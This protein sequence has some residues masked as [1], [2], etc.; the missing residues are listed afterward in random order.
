MP[1]CTL[2]QVLNRTWLLVRESIAQK[3]EE[4]DYESSKSRVWWCLTGSFSFLPIHA[5]FPP[6]KPNL[7]MM[8]VVV[9]SYTFTISTL[10]QAQQRNKH[11]RPT[12][13]MLAVG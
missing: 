1:S 13:R 3:F 12:F 11:K 2:E 6:G 5:S 4:Q 7:G 9:S 8:D 10:L